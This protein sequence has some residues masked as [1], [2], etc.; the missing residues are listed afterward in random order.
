MGYK[1]KTGL[2]GNLSINHMRAGERINSVDIPN[3]IMNVGKSV[4]SAFI[5]SDIT[6]GVAFDYMS[7]GTSGVAA[8]ATQTTL[9]SEQLK[10][11]TAASQTTT[12]TTNDTATFI[13][14]FGISGTHAIVEAGIFNATGA[15]TGSMLARTT[16]TALNV[17]SGDA[18]NATWDVTVA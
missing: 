18:I 14:S 15:D 3:T 7:I 10:V 5:G 16:F 11:G 1:D 6:G 13:G 17:I 12:T 2:R 8:A 4:V 9:G